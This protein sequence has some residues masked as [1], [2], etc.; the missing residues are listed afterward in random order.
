MEFS[1]SMTSKNSGSNHVIVIDENARKVKK[2]H[3]FLTFIAILV[4]L[5]VIVGIVLWNST[6][7]QKVYPKPLDSSRLPSKHCPNF[8]SLGSEGSVVSISGTLTFLAGMTPDRESIVIN[9]LKYLDLEFIALVSSAGRLPSEFAG[10]YICV[11]GKIKDC[12]LLIADGDMP[13]T[14]ESIATTTTK[15][16]ETTLATAT[17]TNLATPTPV[18]QRRKVLVVYF[19][20]DDTSLPDLDVRN[21]TISA[22]ANPSTGL[23]IRNY[24]QNMS[25]GTVLLDAS[26][27]Y[28]TFS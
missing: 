9:V 8:L 18:I 24:F 12:S 6:L 23:G 11:Q 27:S 4:V 21:L 20:Y 15:P 1:Q 17:K 13:Y 22:F 16:I 19:Y 28:M 7:K 3:R 2:S 10:N 14:C 26:F 25:Y 5:A